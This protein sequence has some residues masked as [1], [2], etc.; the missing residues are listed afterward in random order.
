MVSLLCSPQE[1][2]GE[3]RVTTQPPKSG[4]ETLGR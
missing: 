3:D 4:E 1:Q 2:A